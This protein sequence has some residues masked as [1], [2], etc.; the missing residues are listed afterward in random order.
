MKRLILTAF[1]AVA[2][3]AAPLGG[4]AY[5]SEPEVIKADISDQEKPAMPV[6]ERWG[7]LYAGVSLGH[8]FLKDTIPAEGKDWIFGGFAGYNHQWGNFVAG[9]EGS[10]DSADILFTDGSGI[11]SE[12]IYSARVRAGW[13]NDKVLIYGSLGL[14]HGTTTGLPPANGK[15]SALQLG[16]G[17]EYAVTRNI[18]V[19]TDYTYTKYKEFGDLPLDVS[20]QRLQ[21]RVSYSFK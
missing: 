15:D 16:G 19:G 9:V 7:G 14:E 6:S 21:A 3:G 12:Y 11:A 8:G 13:A 2:A 17:I 20:T 4:L 1:M 5:A 10:I 18:A